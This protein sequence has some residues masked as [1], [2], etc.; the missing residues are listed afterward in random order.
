MRASLSTS[1]NELTAWV[2]PWGV[3]FAANL[4]PDATG[5]ARWTPETFIQA[6]RTGKHAGVGHPILPPMP[7]LDYSRELGRG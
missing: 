1:Y 3:S 5:L 7:W 4:M 2:G 6:M